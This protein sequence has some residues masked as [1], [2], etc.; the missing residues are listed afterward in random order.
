[1]GF[2]MRQK[3]SHGQGEHICGCK[4]GRGLGEGWSKRLRLAV[5]Y[6]KAQWKNIF[7]KNIYIMHMYN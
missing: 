7:I 3:Q 4:R 6:E 5:S 2:S 1:M